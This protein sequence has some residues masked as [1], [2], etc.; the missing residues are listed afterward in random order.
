MKPVASKK[1]EKKSD[2]P[3][4]LRKIVAEDARKYLSVL[5]MR[6]YQIKVM[7]MFED[8]QPKE[9][10]H[11]Q[12]AASAEVDMR[13]L[14]LSVRVFPHMVKMWEKGNMSDEEVHEIIAHEIAHTATQHMHNLAIATFKDQGETLD[15]WE[16]LT[17][18]VGRLLHEVERR[19]S[20]FIRKE[21]V[22]KKKK[23]A[24]KK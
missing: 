13:Y 19:R 5:G 11:G 24:R 7:Y 14:R 9:D 4:K 17:T 6:H 15:A 16:A 3:D 23:H 12:V 22:K 1:Q 21:E 18:I 10:H 20:G 8:E 2:V